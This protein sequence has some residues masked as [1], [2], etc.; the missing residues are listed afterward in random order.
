MLLGISFATVFLVIFV[1]FY[2]YLTLDPKIEKS[3]RVRGRIRRMVRQEDIQAAEGGPAQEP[4]SIFKDLSVSNIPAL[5]V[6]LQRFRQTAALQ[7]VIDQSNL[8]VKAS[9]VL[10]AC[11]ALLLGGLTLFHMGFGLAL[12]PALLLGCAMAS[13][14]IL[15]ILFQRRRRFRK[16][17]GQ[18]PQGLDLIARALKAGYSFPSAL[19]MASQELPDPIAL[20]LKVIYNLQSLGWT[21]RQTML[22]FVDRMPQSDVKLFVTAT[23]IHKD[24]GGNL[25]EVLENAAGV[26]R[27]RFVLRRQLRSMTAQARMSGYLM[28]G[29]PFFVIGALALVAP[30]YIRLLFEDPL[31]RTMC[32][33]GIIMLTTGVLT[34]RKLLQI[35]DV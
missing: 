10:L 12:A 17:E 18:F 21:M 23:L 26:I 28:T 6:I 24:I 8:R 27:Q 25:A 20:E 3:Q 33:V 7:K 35:K 1:L 31:G 9:V 34:I 14:P 13:L 15:Y 4:T 22:N 11:G 29:L 30:D 2:F 5:N 32:T 16:F 19:E